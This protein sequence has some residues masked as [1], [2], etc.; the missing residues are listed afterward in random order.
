MESLAIPSGYEN[1]LYT[2]GGADYRS[3]G[4]AEAVPSDPDP[5]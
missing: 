5:L 4:I 3:D 1:L 2:L